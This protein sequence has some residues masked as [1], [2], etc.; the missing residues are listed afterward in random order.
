MNIE[1][2]FP[3]R[4]LIIRKKKQFDETNHEEETQ[5]IEEYLRFIYF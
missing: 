5:T 3:L 4:H 1:P 2:T